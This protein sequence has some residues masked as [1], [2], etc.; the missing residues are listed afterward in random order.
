MATWIKNAQ[1]VVAWDE[2][3]GTHGYLTDADVVFED[4]RLTHVGRG[5]AGGADQ[6]V[7]GKGLMVMPG[8]VN[9]HSHPGHEPLYRGIREEH[10]RPSQYMT[11]LYERSLA[12]VSDE[13][14]ELA[15]AEVAYCELLLSG[16]TT[17]ADLSFPYDGWF[18]LLDRSGL[19]A[20]VAPG[21]ASARW[22]LENDH[23]LKFVWT[24]PPAAVS[25]KSA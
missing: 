23:E 12:F 22:L 9:I 1:W 21:Y 24:R 4:D 17:L 14:A 18:D 19:R 20:Y 5:Y 11:G 25:S 13:A 8:L 10:G 2:A 16:V 15:G 6:V 3:T 7:D